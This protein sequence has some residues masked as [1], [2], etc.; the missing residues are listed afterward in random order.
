MNRINRSSL[1]LAALCLFSGIASS[2]HS[3]AIYD[4]EKSVTLQGVVKSFQWGNPHNYIQVVVPNGKG[5]Q[6]EWAVEAGT[7]ATA[8]ASGWSKSTLKAG[9]KVTL[10]VGPMKDGSPG[11]TLKIATLADGRQLRSVAADPRAA[12]VFDSIPS[13]QRATPKKQP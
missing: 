1:L 11:G 7:P 10:V 13:L 3:T 2:H 6:V 12:K 9:D 4:F 8:S 5:G